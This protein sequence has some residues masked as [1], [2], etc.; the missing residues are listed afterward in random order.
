MADVAPKSKPA[1]RSKDANPDP[2][3]ASISVR[4]FIYF[5]PFPVPKGID[6]PYTLGLPDKNPLNLPPE[7]FEPTSTLVLTST[8][9]TFVDIRIFRPLRPGDPILPTDGGPRERLEWAFSGKAFAQEIPDPFLISRPG[10]PP[11]SATPHQWAGPIKSCAWTHWIDSRHHVNTPSHE[12]PDDSGIMYPLTETKTL[13]H[14]SAPNPATGK[15]QTH[16][17][18]WS[19][20]K[21]EACWPSK[22]KWSI[23]LRLDALDMGVRG[24]AIRLG[25]YAQAVLMDGDVA[26]VERWEYKKVVAGA[27]KGGEGEEEERWEW[28]KT[29]RIGDGSLP[30]PVMLQ[31]E[32]SLVKDGIVQDGDYVWVVE[33]KVEWEDVERS[34]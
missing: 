20:R 13:E 31:K 18:L 19:E 26:T 1:R 12:M 22:S 4:D 14:G 21:I 6:M 7:G 2:R 8:G 32:S 10:G 17:E 33:E 29:V 15:M 34:E 27:K 30:C 24:V 25:R 9:K 3:N 16:E 28:E 11:P 23:V 5:L